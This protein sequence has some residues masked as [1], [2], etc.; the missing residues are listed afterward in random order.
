MKKLKVLIV[1]DERLSRDEIKRHL[2][3][4][5]DFEIAGEAGNA[6]EA[7]ELIKSVNPNVIFLDVQM[8]GRSGF[9]LLE[10]LD[11]VSE[12][13]FTTAFEKYAVQAFEINALDYLVK[14]VREERFAKTIEKIRY[15][16]SN[17][18]ASEKASA[19]K[20]NFF[21][22][23][24]E[25]Y[26]FIKMNDISL[27]ESSGN[28]ARLQFLGKKVHIKR[29]LN[30]LENIL[31]PLH[32]FRINRTAIINTDYLTEVK[33]LPGGRLTISLQTGKPLIV[34]ARQSALFKNKN[35]TF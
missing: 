17:S 11:T 2:Q 30:Q 20:D 35:K 18:S 32:F 27:I 21:V 9:D 5:A 15:K 4:Y 13:I 12:I 33:P 24:G 22:K 23:E 3:D 28:Y 16:F 6:D 10:S 1:D 19:V 26:Y 25:R 29:S 14:P 31:D 7:E 8:P 34:S